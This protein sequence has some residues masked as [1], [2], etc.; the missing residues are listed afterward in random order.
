MKKTSYFIFVIFCLSNP[1]RLIAQQELDLQTCISM[2]LKNNAA[3]QQSQLDLRRQ[4]AMFIQ[5]KQSLLPD[6]NAEINYSFYNGTIFDQ[7]AARQ[8][9]QTSE[10]S[11]PKA[12]SN[13]ILFNGFKYLNRYHAQRLQKS[14]AVEALKSTK[15]I[16]TIQTIQ[17]YYT[18]LEIAVKLQIAE[19]RFNLLKNQME[20]TKVEDS[21]GISITRDI[22]LLDAQVA[23]E[24]SN[25]LLLKNEYRTGLNQFLHYLGVDDIDAFSLKT[26]ELMHPQEDDPFLS[27]SAA[28]M[29]QYADNHP[30]VKKSQFDLSSAELMHKANK[31]NFSPEI[32]IFGEYGTNYSSNGAVNPE[33]GLFLPN[34]NYLTQLDFNQYKFLGFFMKIPLYTRGR[35]KLDKKLTEISLEEQIITSRE[36]KRETIRQ[37]NQSVTDFKFAYENFKYNEDNFLAQQESK[38]VGQEL[39]NYGKIDFFKY[40][41]ILN[42][43]HLAELNREISRLRFY[44]SRESLEILLRNISVDN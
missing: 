18:M 4:E 11:N 16:V 33:N 21:L 9:T 1:Y 2:A 30:A 20:L 14:S 26:I 39:Y 35:N 28:E 19:E 34:A 27:L 7:S 37:I 15:E 36:Q 40:R 3:L 41:A 17:N 24:K 25:L 12:N 42:E 32:S 29:M 13:F 8:V 43:F 22:F 31:Y 5:S 6:L 38:N 23:K 44:S 10:L